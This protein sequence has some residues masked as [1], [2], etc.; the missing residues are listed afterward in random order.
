MTKKILVKIVFDSQC[1]DWSDWNFV[2]DSPCGV[3]AQFIKKRS[4]SRN[5]T[6]PSFGGRK[7]IGL[8]FEEQLKY[9]NIVPNSI[10][11]LQAATIKCG[12]F[13]QK[14]F[15]GLFW[16]YG[17][18]TDS[19]WERFHW[20]EFTNRVPSFDYFDQ[21]GNQYIRQSCRYSEIQHLNVK[22]RNC[23]KTN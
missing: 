3:H 1:S 15:T 6:Q 19:R 10:V 8:K 22:K 2:Y 4:H 23:T 13:N 17:N 16:V 9:P 14:L 21:E 20:T 5:C 18:L 7:C 12:Q 11:A